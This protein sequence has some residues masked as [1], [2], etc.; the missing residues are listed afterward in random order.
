MFRIISFK[1]FVRNY[2]WLLNDGQKYVT[3]KVDTVNQI[4]EID[5]I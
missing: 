2:E 1:T 3:K 5:L 4:I